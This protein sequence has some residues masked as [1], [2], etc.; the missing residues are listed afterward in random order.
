M[1]QSYACLA[2]AQ[3]ADGKNAEAE[4]LY[5][6]ALELAEGGLGPS[7]PVLATVLDKYADLLKKMKRDADAAQMEGLAKDVR[8]GKQVTLPTLT[9]PAIQGAPAMPS[10]PVPIGPA[11]AP[12]APAKSTEPAAPAK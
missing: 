4:S 6:K 12:S 7:N 10:L 1:M 5:K 11:A 9:Q 2:E 3:K 8:D